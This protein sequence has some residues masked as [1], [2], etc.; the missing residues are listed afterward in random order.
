LTRQAEQRNIETTGH[1]I[2]LLCSINT[3]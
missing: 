1:C 3:R 2:S